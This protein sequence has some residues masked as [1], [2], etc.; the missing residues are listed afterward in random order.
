MQL[1]GKD[2]IF[3]MGNPLLDIS[4]TDGAEP[5]LMTKYDLPRGMSILAEK[6]HMPM[7][8]EVWN[9]PNMTSMLGGAAL[10]STRA[11]AYALR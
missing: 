7:F 2:R 9:D 11:C 1:Q 10:N 8:A 6:K 4:V 3:C 5:N